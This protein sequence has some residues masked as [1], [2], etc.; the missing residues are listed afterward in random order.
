MDDT[1][2]YK[3]PWFYIAGWLA[4]LLIIYGWAIFNLGIFRI[5][6][7]Y[8]V[9][10]ACI[11]LRSSSFGW[12]FSAFVLP[13]RTFRHR[14]GY[15]AGSSAIFLV[16]TVPHCLSKTARSRNISVNGTKKDRG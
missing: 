11:F 10:L 4:V 6:W 3:R 13:V 2:F 14:R 16:H 1:P 15:S 12:R 8:F 7:Q 5:T 9:D